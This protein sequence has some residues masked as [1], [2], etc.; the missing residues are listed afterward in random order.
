MEENAAENSP[1][2]QESSA[3]QLGSIDYIEHIQL[4]SLTNRSKNFHLD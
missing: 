4:T 2:V 3:S 1:A